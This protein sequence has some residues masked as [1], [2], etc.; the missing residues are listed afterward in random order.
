MVETNIRVV[1][2]GAALSLSVRRLRVKGSIE[3][4]EGL[5]QICGRLSSL[6]N[7]ARVPM[8]NMPQPEILALSLER[9][10]SVTVDFENWTAEVVD[11]GLFRCLEF[12]NRCDRFLLAE[13][14]Q[15]SLLRRMREANRRRRFNSYRMWYEPEPFTTSGD[16]AAFRRYAVSS[17]ILEGTGIGVAVDVG[18]AFFTTLTVADYFQGDDGSAGQNRFEQLSR[19]QRGHKGTLLYDLGNSKH[20]A[21]FDQYCAGVTCGT[22]GTIRVRGNTYTSLYDYIRQTHP[23]VRIA[24]E[25]P[26]ARVSFPGLDRPQ[27]VPA[28]R[29]RLRVMND[30]LPPALSEAHKFRPGERKALIQSFWN[31]LG[32][33]PF[34]AGELQ[35]ADIFWRPPQERVILLPPPGLNFGKARRIDPPIERSLAAYR[36]WFRNRIKNLFNGGMWVPEI[37]ARDFQK[38]WHTRHC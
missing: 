20:V 16:I 27:P 28:K 11:T 12:S 32:G 8:H 23:S 1:L 30:A 38:F 7:C 17:I 36:A 15:R 35:V 22:T 5:Q 24:P 14:L 10:A 9:V 21:Y 6:I 3:E 37:L 26:V 34:G 13:L 2:P 4:P 31:L 29:L 19:R 18:T 25:E 33:H